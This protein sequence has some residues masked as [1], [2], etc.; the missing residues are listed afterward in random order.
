MPTFVTHIIIGERVFSYLTERHLQP[1]DYGPFLLGCVLADV[2]NFGQLD[3]RQTHFVG[4]IDEEGQ[5]AFTKSCENFLTRLDGLLM[6]PWPELASVERAFVAGYMCHL[7]SDEA[8]KKFSW[9]WMQLLEIRS[10]AEFPVPIDVV[11]TA[12]DVLA[13]ELY[14]DRAAIV[15]ALTDATIPRV[16]THVPYQ[17]FQRMWALVRTH[18]LDS[19][20]RESYLAFLERTGKSAEEMREIRQRHDH[21]WQDALSL[22]LNVGGPEPAVQE[23]VEQSSQVIP[24]LWANR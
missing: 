23:A 5:G 1:A 11:L 19:P 14:R 7:A 16:M 6:H 4:R 12:F 20:S 13:A 15:A 21:Y 17:D 9:T 10:S 22:L 24:A 2:N 3:R 18:A 8:W